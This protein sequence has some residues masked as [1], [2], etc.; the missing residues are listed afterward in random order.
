MEKAAALDAALAQIEAHFGKGPDTLRRRWLRLKHRLRRLWG[1]RSAQD[2]ADAEED[3]EWQ[4]EEDRRQANWAT[5]SKE[6]QD[7][8]WAE[9]EAEHAPNG[10][11]F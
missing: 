10:L 8:T 6:Q 2:E 3:A 7:A 1:W 11:P 9:W 5:M 4:A